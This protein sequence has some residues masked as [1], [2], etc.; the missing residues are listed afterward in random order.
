VVICCRAT[1]GN[2]G[3]WPLFL[4]FALRLQGLAHSD[5]AECVPGKAKQRGVILSCQKCCQKPLPKGMITSN[6]PSVD[7]PV[8]R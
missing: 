7:E 2:L 6:L 8:L 3:F 5:A 4:S 1:V